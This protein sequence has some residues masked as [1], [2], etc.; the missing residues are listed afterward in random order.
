VVVHGAEDPVVPLEAGR[1]VAAN[2]PGAELRI[3]P[4]MGHQIP[5]ALVG[6]FADAI[7]AAA[8]RAASARQTK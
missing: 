6:T 2:I 8:A 5:L 4:G 7:A 1:D 3:I